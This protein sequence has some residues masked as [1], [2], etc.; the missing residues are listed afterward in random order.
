MSNMKRQQVNYAALDI[1]REY[2]DEPPLVGPTPLAPEATDTMTVTLNVSVVVDLNG[3]SPEEIKTNLET[4]ILYGYENGMITGDSD[5]EVLE[6]DYDVE[7]L[8]LDFDPEV[9]RS[10]RY[11]TEVL[12][13][14]KANEEINAHSENLALLAHHFGT[15]EEISHCERRHDGD[16][17]SG[18]EG[19]Q[20]PAHVV[21]A[22]NDYYYRLVQLTKD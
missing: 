14:Y 17:Q 8:D 1:A 5:A 6:L 22:I 13:R 19:Y 7:I 16:P 15:E 11:P 21:R 4:T 10:P 2:S 20:I 18:E 3:A 9:L 12:D